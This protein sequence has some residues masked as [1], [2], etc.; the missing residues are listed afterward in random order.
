MSAFDTLL[1]PVEVALAFAV[2]IVLSSSFWFHKRWLVRRATLQKATWQAA[3]TLFHEKGISRTS[4]RNGV[5]VV[6]SML[7][8]TIDVVADIGIDPQVL[9]TEW[10]QI[11]DKLR[12]AVRALDFDGFATT[13]EELGPLLGRVMPRT[14]DDVNELPDEPVMS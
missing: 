12:A 13:L 7:E 14:E 5:L 2:G 11:Q 3:C 4:G 10:S 6:V 9:G 8:R 1:A